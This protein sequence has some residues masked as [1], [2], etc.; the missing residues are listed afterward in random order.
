MIR[1]VTLAFAALTRKTHC[2]LAMMIIVLAFVTMKT[3]WQAL[4]CCLIEIVVFIAHA[5]V[6]GA[7]HWREAVVR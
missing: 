6:I 3:L 5:L 2:A 1:V 7:F 4:R